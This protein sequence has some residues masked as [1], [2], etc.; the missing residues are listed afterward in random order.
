MLASVRQG[1]VLLPLL[2]TV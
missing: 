1:G 2:F